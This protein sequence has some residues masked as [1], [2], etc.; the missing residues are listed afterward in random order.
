[1]NIDPRNL[2]SDRLVFHPTVHVVATT[3]LTSRFHERVQPGVHQDRGVSAERL[4]EFAGRRC[5]D[6]VTEVLTRAGWKT[7]A[8]LAPGEEICTFNI[9]QP[10]LEFLDPGEIISQPFSG[11]LFVAEGR[12]FS[13]HVTPDHN[14]VVDRP[15]GLQLVRANDAFGTRFNVPTQAVYPGNPATDL[16]FS[17]LTYDQTLPNSSAQARHVTP[18]WHVPKELMPQFAALLG[19]YVAEGTITGGHGAGLQIVIYQKDAKVQPIIDLIES[20]G[21]KWG[22]SVDARNGVAAL[23]INKSSLVR[24]LQQWGVGSSN[25]RVPPIVFDWPVGVRQEFINAAMMGDGHKSENGRW[26]YTTRSHGLAEDMQRLLVT[27]GKPSS[28]SCCI[29]GGKPIYRVSVG[30]RPSAEIKPRNQSWVPYSGVVYCVSTKNRALLIRRDGKVLICGNCYDSYG[31]GRGSQEYHA[32]IIESGH[33]S[34]L[35][36]A[37]LTFEISGVS[38][39][40]THELVRHRV[41]VAISQRSTRYVD[42]SACRLIVP[43]VFVIQPSDDDEVATAKRIQ[44]EVLLKG[45]QDS[46][47]NYA[48]LVHRNPHLDRKAARGAA[49]ST[50]GNGIETSLVWTCNLRS[51]LNVLRQRG[52]EAADA[53][54]RRLAVALYNQALPYAPTIFGECVEL[55]TATDG[56][57]ALKVR[58]P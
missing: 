42:E 30:L 44:Q 43:P 51:L 16:E 45:H 37:S 6:E 18:G 23:R 50:L 41:G 33:G 10:E 7:F 21:L 1:M 29:D 5:Y 2:Q 4:I 28:I 32:H 3:T 57:P 31:K 54:I 22:K 19:W 24:W 46:T 20:L 25:L 13:L 58:S 36:H 34:V 9:Q 47:A 12:R 39:G 15:A 55:F 17:G 11:K 48:F 52:S 49:R 8:Q 35:E 26:M 53:E 56:V 27:S 40:L 38:R 14:L